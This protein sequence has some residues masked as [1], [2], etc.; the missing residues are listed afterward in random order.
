MPVEQRS[1]CVKASALCSAA[2][3]SYSFCLCLKKQELTHTHTHTHARTRA[4]TQ[5]YII[6]K[7]NVRGH[8][9]SVKEIYSV[10]DSEIL[11]IVHFLYICD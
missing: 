4:H 7:L 3:S 5:L 6:S 8:I 10:V 1:F 9:K 11:A 2:S